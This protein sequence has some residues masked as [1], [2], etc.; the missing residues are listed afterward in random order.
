M[1]RDMPRFCGILAG[2]MAMKLILLTVSLF[3]GWMCFGKDFTKQNDGRL[4]ECT[5]VEGK[6]VF[7][8]WSTNLTAGSLFWGLHNVVCGSTDPI[9]KHRVFSGLVADY[10]IGTPRKGIPIFM[11][12]D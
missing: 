4:V 6:A 2:S 5:S 11:A 12:T 10:N 9:E 3:S 8:Q 7:K 1:K